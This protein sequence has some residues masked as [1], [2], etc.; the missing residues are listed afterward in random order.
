MAVF[1]VDRAQR[2]RL[3][4]KERERARIAEAR[5]RAQAA[6]EK[7]ETLQQLDALKSRF[8]AN[9]SHEFRTPLTLIIDPLDRMIERAG[10]GTQRRELQMMRRQALRLL[11]LVGQLLDLS[12]LDAGRMTLRAR[13]VD[14]VP[15]LRG[16]VYAFASRAER[17]D[18]ALQFVTD[19]ETLRVYAEPDKLEKIFSNLLSNAFKFTPSSGKIRVGVSTI[20]DDVGGF[21][22]VIQGV[23][24]SSARVLSLPA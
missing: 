23:R 13:E 17:E 24:K 22:E 9:L 18:I 16:L 12:K 1:G 7:A 5:L 6:Q 20:S 3:V 2:R 10:R 4:A 11:D 15:F 21:A 8:F 14:L 19:T